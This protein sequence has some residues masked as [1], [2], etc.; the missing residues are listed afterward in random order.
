M[1]THYLAADL[2]F[3]CTD[4]GRDTDENFDAFTDAVAD[5]LLALAEVD[6]GIIDPD[7]TTVITERWVSVLI[8]ITADTFD[9]AVR[10]FSA[11]VR[12]AL[13]ATGCGTPD[14]PMF[15]PTTPTPRVRGAD[16]AGA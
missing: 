3:I 7:L 6:P 8:G 16:F 10:L 1:T 11:N 4:P 9:D 14:W 15:K 13:H 12:S 2:N 5:E